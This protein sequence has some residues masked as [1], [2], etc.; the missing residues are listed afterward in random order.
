LDDLKAARLE[1]GLRINFG[2]Y[3]FQIRKFAWDHEARA[4]TVHS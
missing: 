4:R 2:S 1:P 3:K